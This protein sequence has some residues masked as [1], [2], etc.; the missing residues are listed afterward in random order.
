M[1]MAPEEPISITKS[2]LQMKIS[3]DVIL[4]L[5]YWLWPIVAKTLIAHSFM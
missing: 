3:K 5:D 1:E 4:M 2:I